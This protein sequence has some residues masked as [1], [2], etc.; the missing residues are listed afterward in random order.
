M[1]SVAALGYRHNCGGQGKWKLQEHLLWRL[2]Q[3]LMNLSEFDATE[4]ERGNCFNKHT[5]PA[6]CDMRETTIK[7][8]SNGLLLGRF[9]K[10]L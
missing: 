5:I 2:C 7:F 1:E 8:S 4:H 3:N 9:S 6:R 10:L